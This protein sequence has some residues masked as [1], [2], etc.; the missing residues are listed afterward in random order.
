M[1]IKSYSLLLL[2][3]S[4][5]AC[6][7]APVPHD[8]TV[9]AVP[10]HRVVLEDEF[11]R[12]R[13]ETNR[14]VTIPHNF[15]QME[16]QG[17][18]HN[19][20]LA[21]KADTGLHM[22]VYPFYDSDAYKNIEAAAYSLKT[23]PDTVLSKRVAGLITQIDRAQEDDGYLYTPRTN[24]ATRLES[25][26]GVRR[27]EKLE[28]SHELY[29]AGHLYEAGIA[30]QQATGSDR[31]MRIAIK[32]ANL[33]ADTFGPDRLR[34]PPGHQEV[35]LALAKMYR[36]TQDA[37]YLKTAKF[38]LDARGHLGDRNKLW[39]FYAQD[40]IPITQQSEAVGHAV[41]F[42]YMNMG[43]M[44]V[45]ALTGDPEYETTSLRLWHNV[46]SK[47][48]YLTGGIGS[49]G[50]GEGFTDNY[51]LPNMTAYSETCSSIGNAFWNHRLFLKTG[52]AR[53]VDVMERILYNALLS[54]VGF[55]GNAFFY[56]NPLASKGQH[57]RSRW[58]VCACC[59][60]NM[61]RFLPQVPGLIYGIRGENLYVNLFATSTADLV[62]NNHAFRLKQETKY[63]WNGRIRLT[64]QSGSGQATFRLRIPG[65]VNDQVLPSDLYRFMEPATSA[66]Q[67]KINGQIQLFSSE[68]GYAVIRRMWQQGDVL[69]WSLPMQVRRV[70]AHEKVAQNKNRMALQY[71]PIVFA[72]EGADY[73]D[74]RVH[75]LYVPDTQKLAFRYDANLLSGLGTL[76]GQAQAVYKDASNHIKSR[77]VNFKAIPY[78]AWSHR[79]RAEMAVWIPR[80]SEP[81]TAVFSP[82][83]PAQSL[84]K[85]SG[86]GNAELLRDGKTNKPFVWTASGGKL[87]VQYD[88]PTT[89][90][91]SQVEVFWDTP[92]KSWSVSA[93]YNGRW[94]RIWNPS[95]VW[96]VRKGWNR[97]I[98]ETARTQQIRLEVEPEGTQL[99]ALSE[100]KVY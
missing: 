12:P 69:E 86:G 78:F 75:H 52:D 44:D 95:E 70:T 35:E 9:V 36:T 30:H 48:M 7:H 91:V 49:V 24:R 67:L 22:G 90:E 5:C 32:N 92:P 56:D 16:A 8:Y 3:C 11:W 57:A 79:G 42:V 85:T 74:G 43:I 26:A 94:H 99:P 88:F 89:Q 51:D 4:L 82:P 50:F 38:F 39:D 40:Y 33:V 45:A 53:Y 27:W 80:S 58:F 59:P 2:L 17:T 47:K 18:L 100:W 25:W 77:K 54:G 97:V 73:P 87:W 46:T 68:R 41:R 72:A 10:Y 96:G 98:L 63:P 37:R 1:P 64:V 81:A 71:G 28:G 34:M 76:V 14:Q 62:V 21:A 23:H 19:F 55:S 29:C 66:P 61:A 13:L 65:W 83:L 6:Q 93:L 84:I 31:L 60:P 20:R 15:D